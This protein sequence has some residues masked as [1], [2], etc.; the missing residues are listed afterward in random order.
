V[1]PILTVPVYSIVSIIVAPLKFVNYKKSNDISRCFAIV[2]IAGVDKPVLFCPVPL[3]CAAVT[4]MSR[5]KVLNGQKMEKKC[6]SAKCNFYNVIL[7]ER[8]GDN[9]Q[10]NME[11]NN[12]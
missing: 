2:S 9:K 12:N 11:K 1:L 4:K 3:S 8:Q 7:W 6:C 5:Q 10:K